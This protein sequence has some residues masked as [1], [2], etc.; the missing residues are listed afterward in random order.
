MAKARHAP[1]ALD[2]WKRQI[3]M[4]WNFLYKR[5]GKTFAKIG[6][7]IVGVRQITITNGV[8]E[9][10]GTPIKLHGIDRHELWPDVG[11]ALTDEKMLRDRR[12]DQ[13]GRKYQF[14]PHFCA[15]S[16]QPRD[17]SNCAISRVFFMFCAKCRLVPQ[18]KSI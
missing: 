9:L 16:S 14:H 6:E 18:A 15:L 7:H 8:L 12:F 4:G 10:N 17:S 3:Y 11:R 2:S 1:R 13:A 5:Q